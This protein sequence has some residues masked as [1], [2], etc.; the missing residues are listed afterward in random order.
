M[1]DSRL[2]RT[3][4]TV[5]SVLFGSFCYLLLPFAYADDQLPAAKGDAPV[6]RIH[7]SFTILHKMVPV[8][9]S[10]FLK[11]Q[12]FSDIKQSVES[13]PDEQLITAS[14]PE[15][16]P[17]K[18]ELKANGSNGGLQDLIDR[19]ADIAV[20]SGTVTPSEAK[21]LASAGLGDIY[22]PQEQHVVGLEGLA[23]V[24]NK[25]NPLKSL[26]INDLAGLFSGK[27]KKWSALDGPGWKVTVHALEDKG[28]YNDTFKEIILQSRKTSLSDEAKLYLRDADIS[29]NVSA[30]PTGI[31]Y[32]S[33]LFTL[34]AKTLAISD[35]SYTAVGPTPENIATEDYPLVR[36]V[37]FL[38][39]TVHKNP[40]AQALV[41]FAQTDEG[42]AAV[43]RAGFVGQALQAFNV[44]P[45]HKMP[46]K[47][48][49][50]V[51]SAQ[52]LSVNFRFPSDGTRLDDK[53]KNDI[54]RVADYIQRHK[55][56]HFA[57]AAFAGDE[58]MD[59]K[60][61]EAAA[62]LRA[63]AVRRALYKAGVTTT[64]IQNFGNAL[65]VAADG[66]D[67]GRHRNQRVEV[68]I[69]P[70]RQGVTSTPLS[71]NK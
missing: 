36:R 56:G 10:D 30:D 59:S 23:V 51:D 40:W 24:V 65:P 18:I 35:G 17:I 16:F 32:A 14:S 15:G 52:R 61:A 43:A 44:K 57:L 9:V 11:S 54:E 21:V 39:P 48:R 7:G 49:E 62:Y 69:Y 64:D 12:R 68:W 28:I 31:G 45:H 60:Q 26:T 70:D 34:G 29:K 8:V 53:G 58:S 3:V 5:N 2:G 37:F 25:V 6:L 46:E 41:N 20:Y 55:V 66:T 4:K 47:Y 33:T 50:L 13:T 42:Q 27:I 1:A 63:L 38:A 67:E 22:S 19:S 71:S